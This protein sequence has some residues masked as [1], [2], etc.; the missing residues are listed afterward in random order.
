[1]MGKKCIK[2]DP[3]KNGEQLLVAPPTLQQTK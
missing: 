1:M 3:T 2:V